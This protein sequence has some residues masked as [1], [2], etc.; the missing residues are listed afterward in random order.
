MEKSNC[1]KIVFLRRIVNTEDSSKQ[2]IVRNFSLIV[3]RRV[4]D[5]RKLDICFLEHSEKQFTYATAL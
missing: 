5:N 1:F 2:G 3:M 4:F